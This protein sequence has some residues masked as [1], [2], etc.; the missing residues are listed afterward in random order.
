M[1]NKDNNLLMKLLINLDQKIVLL[2]FVIGI[3]EVKKE[4]TPAK[5]SEQIEEE[6]EE[7]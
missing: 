3:M 1:N 5:I 4:D 2:L 7:E 6:V